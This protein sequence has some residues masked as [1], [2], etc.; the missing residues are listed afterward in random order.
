MVETMVVVLLDL[1]IAYYSV[2]EM[3][4]ETS[5]LLLWHLKYIQF[6]QTKKKNIM[7]FRA[8]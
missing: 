7:I 4:G 8:Q 1:H 3:G 5:L 6:S 2:W